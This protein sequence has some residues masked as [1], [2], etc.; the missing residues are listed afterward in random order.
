MSWMS[1]G[2]YTIIIIDE[3]EKER[4]CARLWASSL[5]KV[6]GHG[7]ALW[8]LA[9]VCIASSAWLCPARDLVL[10]TRMTLQMP[11]LLS[12]SEPTSCP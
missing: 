8:E 5:A 11:N 3:L 6:D 7:F 2:D 9:A 10:A 1:R 4:S 12:S